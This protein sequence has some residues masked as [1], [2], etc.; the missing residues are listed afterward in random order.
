M[1]IE[2]IRKL[3]LN[4]GK[5][6]QSTDIKK[7]YEIATS[8]LL[9]ENMRIPITQEEEKEDSIDRARKAKVKWRSSESG[10]ASAKR[11]NDARKEKNK[12]K[13]GLQST[14]CGSRE[15]EIKKVQARD[16]S[17]RFMAKTSKS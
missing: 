10:K 8:K 1:K 5:Y 7:M 16:K 13:N 6:D 2:T 4:V 14:T 9:L 12:L 3:G 15:S 11:S 17:G